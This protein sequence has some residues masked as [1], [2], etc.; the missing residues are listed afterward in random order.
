MTVKELI[1]ELSKYNENADIFMF[2]YS[3]PNYASFSGVANIALE[4][5]IVII[6]PKRKKPKGQPS[7]Y[8][9]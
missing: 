3:K 8:S 6:Y 9:Q 5:D 2:D 4:F 7:P 1:I